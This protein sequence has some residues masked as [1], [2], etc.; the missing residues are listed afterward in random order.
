MA[1]LILRTAESEHY[2]MLRKF[3]RARLQ[4]SREVVER[5]LTSSSELLRTTA[6]DH[7]DVVCTARSFFAYWSLCRFKS[8]W[9][10]SLSLWRTSRRWGRSSPLFQGVWTLY[11][12]CFLALL[13]LGQRWKCLRFSAFVLRSGTTW[14]MVSHS[15][16]RSFLEG[17]TNEW[18]CF[19]HIVTIVG[20]KH[21]VSLC[22]GRMNRESGRCVYFVLSVGNV[23]R[24]FGQV[25]A[26]KVDI[27]VPQVNRTAQ[28][29]L[30]IGFFIGSRY[31]SYDKIF[32]W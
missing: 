27:A 10:G 11:S 14:F 19:T 4:V 3:A 5:F 15:W 2:A 12:W 30:I 24:A 31:S 20:R 16:R 9:A 32:C 13:C 26:C 17:N 22:R 6:L 1:P 23:G 21:I 7:L 28:N 25:G 8:T 18:I 29:T